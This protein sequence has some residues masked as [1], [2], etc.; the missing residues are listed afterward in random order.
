MPRVRPPAR[1]IALAVTLLVLPGAL[2]GAQDTAAPDTG[3]QDTAVRTLTERFP[4]STLVVFR[5]RNVGR[6]VTWFTKGPFGRMVRD[7]EIKPLWDTLMGYVE[8]FRTTAKE[9]TGVDFVEMLQRVKGEASLALTRLSVTMSGPRPGLMLLIDCGDER[10]AMQRDIETLLKLVPEGRL[11]IVERELEGYATTSYQ[12][13]RKKAEPKKDGDEGEEDS[14]T[15]RR[16][17]RDREAWIDF[18]GVIQTA[19]IDSTLVISNDRSG[20]TNFLKATKDAKVKAL[21]DTAN[22]VQTMDKLGGTGDSVFYG[23]ITGLTGVI[24][25]AAG[26]MPDE[27]GPVVS[28]L[29]LDEFPSIAFSGRYM[30]NGIRTKA[31]LRYTGDTTTGL[32]ALLQFNRHKLQVPSWIPDDVMDFWMIDYDFDKAFGSLLSLVE[33]A[34]EEPYEDMQDAFQEFE[35]KFGIRLRDDLIGSLVGPIIMMRYGAT[36]ALSD[37]IQEQRFV[38]PAGGAGSTLVGVRI[39]N[40]DPW[41][42]LLEYA[43]G[44]GAEVSNYGP[45]RIVSPPS[46]GMDMAIDLAITNN[47]M[48]AS[49]GT[50]SIIRPVL[51]GLGRTG[52]GLGEIG[53]VRKALEGLPREGVGVYVVNYGKWW[54]NT[55]NLVKLLVDMRASFGSETDVTDLAKWKV[56]SSEVFEK[57]FG[58]A[59]SVMDFKPGVGI[60]MESNIL[61]K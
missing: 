26:M 13:L 12:P 60:I 53:G 39:R 36:S 49:I 33:A 57:Y 43:E 40:R 50:N 21:G 29:G 58:Y 47:Y 61:L 19:W 32:G 35:D 34:G 30:P 3:A 38:F 41:E 4:E 28:A 18:V 42:R 22:W 46:G 15:T 2:V 16:R 45:A 27:V 7:A 37:A 11:R 9:N 52:G 31:I 10:E 8:S 23:N 17:R 1:A 20:F 24:E 51:S 44:M 56:P 6:D 5:S 48:M 54:S 25:A 14:R 59:G 55:A